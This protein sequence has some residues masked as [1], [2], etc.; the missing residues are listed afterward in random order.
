MQGLSSELERLVGRVGLPQQDQSSNLPVERQLEPSRLPGM[1]LA[2]LHQ[3]RLIL[4]P[5]NRVGQQIR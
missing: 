5:P 2:E 1:V 4:T 3:R